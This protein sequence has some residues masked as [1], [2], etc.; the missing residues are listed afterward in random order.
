M[1]TN[2]PAILAA[3]PQL[4]GHGV[5]LNR[6]TEY[7]SRAPGVQGPKAQQLRRMAENP[8]TLYVRRPGTLCAWDAICRL[9]GCFEP[10]LNWDYGVAGRRECAAHRESRRPRPG[11]PNNLRDPRLI[12]LHAEGKVVFRP[13]ADPRRKGVM[14]CWVQCMVE[15][16]S[17]YTPAA[18]ILRGNA[19]KCDLHRAKY[20]V[21]GHPTRSEHLWRD[22]EII[23]AWEAH[24]RTGVLRPMCTC[25]GPGCPNLVRWHS[26]WDEQWKA[27]RKCQDC[28]QKYGNLRPW[29][30]LYSRLKDSA[31]QAGRQVTLTLSQFAHLCE[32]QQ[33][34]HYCGCA[35]ER[36]K[37]NPKRPGQ[38]SMAYFL[39]RIDEE[40][41]YHADNVVVACTP[42][43][44]TRN[45]WLNY[46]EMRVI[47]AMRAG[48]YSQ[49]AAYAQNM[50]ENYSK[51]VAKVV[52][53]THL[54]L[55]RWGGRRT[56]AP[57]PGDRVNQADG[58]LEP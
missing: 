10:L 53:K 32:T 23:T 43:N 47:G 41:D 13:H 21:A 17:D 56:I 8:E 20:I 44:F 34:C 55:S 24:P 15:G 16:C 12:V 39:D 11:D 46:D 58:K 25:T 35:I 50:P 1:P 36:R 29:E 14:V 42:C 22:R 6:R 3:H 18:R 37:L 7:A 5:D 49:A 2:S 45:N 4:I 48:N 54:R 40:Q 57:A 19:P 26:D 52:T 30:A 31:G 38:R 27:N 33:Q 51:H 28:R 9:P